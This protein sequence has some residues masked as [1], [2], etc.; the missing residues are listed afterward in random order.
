MFDEM[1]V[2]DVVSWNSIV[3]VSSDGGSFLESMEWFRRLVVSGFKVNTVSLVSVLPAAGETRRKEFGTTVHGFAVKTGLDSSVTVSNV[4]VDMY[5]KCGDSEASVRVFQRMERRNEVS[6]NS[7]VG[8]LVRMGSYVD[9][10]S[11]FRDMLEDHEVKPNAITVSSLLPALAELEWIGSGKE[12]HGYC[13]RNRMDSDVYVANSLIDMYAKCGCMNKASV[14]FHG[15][16][17]KNVVSWNAV[18]ANLAQN[19]AHSEA[20]ALVIDMQDSG[21]SPNSV[22]FTN[23]L[24]AC[25]R[26]ASLKKGK[27]IHAKAIRDGLCIDLFVS[28]ALIDMYAKCGKLNIAR[29]VFKVS[30]RDQVSYN[31][32]IVGYSESAFASKSLHLFLEMRVVSLRYDIVSFKGVLTACAN[33]SA[34][35]QGKEIH[36]LSIRKLFNTH[37][38]VSNSLLDFYT[39]CGKINIARKIFDR[40]PNKDVASWNAMILGYGMQGELEEAIYLFDLMEGSC[41]EYDQVSYIAVLAACSHGG[42]VDRGKMYFAKMLARNIRPMQMHYACMVDLLGR[43]AL[44]KDAHELIKGMPFEADSNVWGALLGACRVHGNLELGQIAADRLFVLKPEHCGYYICLS[45]MYAEAGRWTKANEIREQ[46]KLRRAMKSPGC[47]WVETGNELHSFSAGEQ[48]EG[49]EDDICYAEPF[50]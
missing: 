9:S 17:N 6:W 48:M 14:V 19:G 42:L 36:C 43:A 26:M 32:L 50:K 8:N 15:M 5:G 37:I 27:E 28:N 49:A 2:R 46:M 16:E 35:K 24:P 12:V 10:V 31:T 1:P 39:K 41:I 21:E 25:A 13:M 45:N 3:S 4:V 47:S 34:L 38:F 18:I 22:T 40:I 29:R 44:L 7:V 11:V 23:V 30:E 20:I 33:L